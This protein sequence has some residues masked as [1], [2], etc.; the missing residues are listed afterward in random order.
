MN[1]NPDKSLYRSAD[2][3]GL[4][5][6]SRSQILEFLTDWSRPATDSD[7]WTYFQL[8][9]PEEKKSLHGRLERLMQQGLLIRNRKQHI[10]LAQRLELILGRVIGH[11]NGHG[12]VEPETGGERLY[13]HFHQMRRVLHG[14]RVLVKR[15]NDRKGGQTEATIVEA[16]IDLERQIVGQFFTE[17]GISF[18]VPEDA[19]YGRDFVIPASETGAANHGDIVVIELQEHPVR[20]RHVTASIKRV[21]GDRK[22]KG[23][24]TEIAINKFELPHE[25]PKRLLKKLEQ[26]ESQWRNPAVEKHR[27][28]IRDLPLVTIDGADARDFDDAVFC[29]AQGTGWRLVVAIADVSHFVEEGS[30][31]DNLARERGTSVY[32]PK[33]VI[34]MLPELLSNGIC[35]LNPG[36][37]RHCLVCEMDIKDGVVE[38]Y[39]FYKAVMHSHARLTYTQVSEILDDPS[40]NQAKSWQHVLPVL[41][42][43]SDVTES[44]Y[45][46]RSDRGT[47]EFDFPEP[48]FTF[49]QDLH[50]KNIGIKERNR[51]HRL[52]EECMLSANICA[53]EILNKHFNKRAVY[54]NHPGPK[55]EDLKQLRDTLGAMGYRLEGGK[56]PNALDYANVIES[57]KE[58][59]VNA[60]LIQLLLLRSLGQA[61]YALAPE[62]HFALSFPLYTHFTSPIRRYPDLIVHRLIKRI[63]LGQ[64]EMVI[65]DLDQDLLGHC[66]FT[67]RR[68]EQAERDV[69][70]QLKAEFMQDK[71]GETFSGTVTSVREFGLFITLDDFFI[72]GL[73]HVTELGYDYFLFDEKHQCLV[74]EKSGQVYR[75]GDAL[76]VVVSRVSLEEGK[77]DFV[78][79]NVDDDQRSRRPRKPKKSGKGSHK[80]QSSKRKGKRK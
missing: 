53:A 59:T 67:E 42:A 14:D 69:I 70:A 47:I 1:K 20:T 49:D 37:D 30:E 16:F 76:Q 44:I 18:V 41:L 27:K 22:S 15:V 55:D 31:L 9:S 25:W 77:I 78:L 60:D 29:E 80:S 74:G 66:N 57:I 75:L 3:S 19:R 13:L 21:I 64:T 34:P 63:I 58:N 35:S 26:Q 45:R 50:L 4:P 40:G 10:L 62:G 8:R 71:L 61:E 28:N 17:S 32:F 52:I 36:E 7:L 65:E 54:R 23:I 72:D 11:K 24:E 38:K 79:E 56:M 51:A 43:L 2:E 46:K 73:V 68:A 48:E 12:F 39:E 33:R 5:V 6:P